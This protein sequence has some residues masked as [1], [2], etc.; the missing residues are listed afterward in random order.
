MDE[1]QRV[2][3][4]DN[5]NDELFSDYFDKLET[6]NY[7]LYQF[8]IDN[9]QKDSTMGIK[10]SVLSYISDNA[11]DFGTDQT[12][13]F[14]LAS[15]VCNLK[16]TVSHVQWVNDF[17]HHND[18]EVLLTVDDF[19]IV[20]I[21]AVEKGI[22]LSHIKQLINA[23]DDELSIYE[24]I[25]NYDG[26]VHAGMESAPRLAPDD[27]S[28]HDEVIVNEASAAAASGQVQ[29]NNNEPGY[30]EMFSSLITVM[31]MK[32]DGHDAAH[33][34][35]ENLNKIIAKFQLALTELS[36]YSAE[37]I[38]KVES[39]KEEVC[40]LNALLN[41][42]Q[43]VM[44]SNQNKINEMRAE[45]VRLNNRIQDAEKAEMHREAINQK[46]NELQNLTLSEQRGTANSIFTY[47]D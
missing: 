34:I 47:S 8:I 15:I 46:I 37:I 33:E 45:I 9:L 3:F 16:V 4:F 31:S 35:D 41:I 40:R 42:Q 30:A 10:D 36:S 26:T 11:A 29:V 32:N 19:G 43:R 5:R 13:L 20:F 18:K 25:L 6:E 21:E 7:N 17:F 22:P 12:F 44:V 14:N 24:K 28:V 2:I 1:E 27:I 23:E 38:H 39:D